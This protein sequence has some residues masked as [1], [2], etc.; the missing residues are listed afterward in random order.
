MIAKTSGFLKLQFL[1]IEHAKEQ[2]RKL[3]LSNNSIKS[4]LLIG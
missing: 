4:P 2:D 1:S 3:N